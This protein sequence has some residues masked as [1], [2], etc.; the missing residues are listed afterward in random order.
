MYCI[1]LAVALAS[2]FA[3]VAGLLLAEKAAGA[4]PPLALTSNLSFNEKHSFLRSAL[5]T[6]PDLIVAGSSM[7]LNNLSGDDLASELPDHPRILNIGAFSLKMSDTRRWLRAVLD[8]THPKKVIVVTGMM[9]FYAGTKWLTPTDADLRSFAAGSRSPVLEFLKYFSLQYY[10]DKWIGLRLDRR[11]R[12]DYSSLAF[13]GTGSVPL[14][15]YYPHV[16]MQRWREVPRGEMVVDEEYRQADQLAIDLRDRKIEAIFV[17]PPIRRE[18]LAA[19]RSDMEK[20]CHRLARA[21][22]QSGQVF[23]DLHDMNLADSFFA[24]YSHLNARGSRAF[25]LE[26]ARRLSR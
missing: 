26:L 5:R 3:L 14:A 15:V 20:H 21:V 7:A 16:D 23:L 1:T 13:D 24:D 4:L 11:S 22:Q 2:G 8:A 6:K 18:A 19:G 17:Q 12:A 10:L 9:D 25:T